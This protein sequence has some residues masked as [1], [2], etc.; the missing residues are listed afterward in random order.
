MRSRPTAVIIFASN[1]VR[2]N[3]LLDRDCVMFKKKLAIILTAAAL[4]SLLSFSHS[5]VSAQTTSATDIILV[6]P[7]EN[8][9]NHPE[10]NWIG[11]SFADSLSSLLNKPGMIVVTG[12]ERA[13]AYQRLRLPLTVLP[14]RATAIKIAREAKASMI[15]IGTYNV[16]LPPADP[17]AP[18]EK[19]P[20]ANITGESHVVRVNEGRMTGDIFDGAWAPRV[21]DFGGDLTDLQKMHGELAYQI[22]VQRDKALS[23]SRN[24][25]V[26]EAMRVPPQAWEA[27][28]KCL[29]TDEH[30]PTRAI[31][32]KNAMRLYAKE[33]GGAVYPEA[34]FQ[35]GRFYLNQNQWKEA[36]EYFTMLQ[37]RE[38][39]YGEAQFYAG[40]SYWKAGD[41]PHALNALV[42]LADEKAMPLV[43]VYNNAGA[44]SVEAARAEKKP[45]ERS[46]LLGQGVKLLSRA[47]DS[48]PDDTMVLFN[49]AYGLFLSEKYSEAAEKLQKVIAG[50]PRDGPA[51]LLLAKAQ[52]RASQS[53][54]AEAADNQARTKMPQAYAKWQTEWQKSQTVPAIVLRS[55]DVLNPIAISDLT[56]TREIEAVKANNAEDAL[57]KI[58]DLYQQGRD[59]EALVE[60]R[61]LLIIEPTNAEAF[62]LSGRINQRRG[63]QE[64][65]IAALKTA[66]FWDPPPKMIEAQILLGRIFLERGDLGEARKYAT[67]AMSIDPNNQEAIALKRLVTMGGP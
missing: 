39:H 61:K 27:Y 53:E 43:G 10:Y 51:F 14:S 7:F 33:K 59:D 15:V 58:R 31:Y 63:D 34:A 45:E 18:S 3:S 66:V 17:K 1:F 56:R 8:V 38:P 25:L 22:L 54:A 11:E 50:D 40:L 46:R 21:Y 41:L 19:P 2:R 42:P 12:D 29:L 16:T 44:V 4:A 48:S 13:V 9:S 47:V 62:L 35:L 23:F 57:N 32:C 36:A 26:Q 67:T 20:P 37:K 52:E 65:A 49:Y 28:Q 5:N 30:D 6:L 24:N 60:I 55:R 64:T